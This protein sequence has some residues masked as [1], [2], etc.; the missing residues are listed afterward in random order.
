MRPSA[1]TCLPAAV[2]A[3]GAPIALALLLTAAPAAAAP[4]ARS[5]ARTVA[6]RPAAAASRPAAA[7]TRPAKYPSDRLVEACRKKADALRRA[8][9]AKMSIVV[10]P[11]FVIAGDM[12]AAQV[13]RYA[14]WS[15]VRPAHA[16]WAGYFRNKPDRA[17]TVLLFAGAKSYERHA[18]EHYPGGGHPYFG[19]YLSAERTMVMNIRTGT[20][21]L[22]HELTHALIAYDF[23]GVPTWFNEGL[24][25]LHEQCNVQER[26]IVGLTNWR[27]PALQRAIRKGTLR[28][29]RELVTARDFYGRRQGDNYAQARYFCMYM[30]EQRL[31]AKFYRHFRA[32]HTGPQADVRAI[33][34][35]FGKKLPEI[36]KAFL[37]WV[38]T[39]RFRG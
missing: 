33:E 4:A 22:V 19:Y 27:L 18:R 24:A 1:R 20:G 13:A 11:P 38:L 34:H 6:T 7:A 39:L 32:R 25:S 12:P 30:Q 26:R 3:R 2:L 8:R 5:P 17:I 29:L 28:P 16:M 21:T 35:V 10:H 23:P 15:V 9:G 36:E 31:L 14:K 37:A